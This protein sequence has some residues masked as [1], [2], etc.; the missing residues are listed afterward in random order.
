[1]LA[2]DRDNGCMRWR[3]MLWLAAGISVGAG[4]GLCAEIAVEGGRQASGPAGGNA[5]CSGLGRCAEIAVEWVS[6]AA[7]LAGVIAGF[8][9]LGALVMGVAG[10][11]GEHRITRG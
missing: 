1:M 6:R 7:G 2:A 11:A 4:A 8:C 9:E 10:L 5:G 3:V